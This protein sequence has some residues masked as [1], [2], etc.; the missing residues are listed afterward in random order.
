MPRPRATTVSRKSSR[1]PHRATAC[2]SGGTTRSA[3]TNSRTARAEALRQLRT[4]LQFVDVDQPVKTL[5]ITSAIP[6]EGKS[7]TA[8]NLALLFAETGRRVLLID[9]DLRRP[10]IAD[11][12]GLE[13]AVGLTTILAGRATPEDVVQ[14][15][16]DGLWVLPSGFVPPNPSELIGSR[17]MADLLGGFREAFDMVILDC[18]P[19]LPV[20]DG[21]V[22]AAR[23]DGALLLARAGKT[24]STQ[25]TAAVNALHKVDA[26]LLGCVFNMVRSD[27]GDA[28]QYYNYRYSARDGSTGGRGGSGGG[29]GPA[30]ETTF[31][32]EWVDGGTAGTRSRRHAASAAA[33]SGH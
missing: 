7:S 32:A 3:T 21:A 20:T 29:D 14:P 24:T 12:F 4:N 5:V 1:E 18:P 9:A 33:R 30:A 26:R 22:A 15:W 16:S 8:C 27:G 6:G 25:I 17:H 28:Y 31:P 13:G 10:R 23:A 11:Y 19:L 2:I